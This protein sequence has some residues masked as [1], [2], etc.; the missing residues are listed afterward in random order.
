[1]SGDGKCRRADGG[2]GPAELLGDTR[3]DLRVVLQQGNIW[4]VKIEVENS[5]VFIDAP[6]VSSLTRFKM[7]GV[8]RC[9]SILEALQV[10]SVPNFSH[11]LFYC[12]PNSCFNNRAF[13]FELGG[14]WAG[15]DGPSHD[16]QLQ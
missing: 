3:C 6:L 15:D 2:P 16:P 14:N 5:L 9:P 1:M 12:A 10:F 4:G 7:K 8:T 11:G 13:G